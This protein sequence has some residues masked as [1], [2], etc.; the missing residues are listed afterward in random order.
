MTSIKHE[1][2][3]WRLHCRRCGCITYSNGEQDHCQ[4]CGA[5]EWYIHNEPPAEQWPK[6]KSKPKR[7]KRNEEHDEQ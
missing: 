2:Y 4:R 6:P 5:R 3:M 7:R 1:R